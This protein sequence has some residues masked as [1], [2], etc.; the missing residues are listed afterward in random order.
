MSASLKFLL[1]FVETFEKI[2]EI[3]TACTRTNTH[4]STTSEVKPPTLV[5]SDST[6]EIEEKK[7]NS[8]AVVSTKVKTITKK[9]RPK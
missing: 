5:I 2:R 3:F 8:V 4:S 9:Q 6:D 1:F 7:I